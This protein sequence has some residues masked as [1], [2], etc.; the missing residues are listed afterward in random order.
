M[1]ELRELRSSL[2]TSAR[3]S[4]LEGTD[5]TI[6]IKIKTLDNESTWEVE[7]EGSWT[8]RQLKDHVCPAPNSSNDDGCSC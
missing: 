2:P 4:R 6:R 7:G 8:V 5:D 1:T 3:Y